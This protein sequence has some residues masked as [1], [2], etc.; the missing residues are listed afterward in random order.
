MKILVGRGRQ[1]GQAAGFVQKRQEQLVAVYA[2]FH[3]LYGFDADIN[4]VP[5]FEQQQPGIAL[6]IMAADAETVPVAEVIVLF[7]F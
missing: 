7:L 5:I 1:L 3:C 6:L 2:F 4:A